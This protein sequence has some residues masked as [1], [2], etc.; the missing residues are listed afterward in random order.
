MLDRWATLP[1]SLAVETRPGLLFHQH[2][3]QLPLLF[4]VLIYS[5]CPTLDAPNLSE[6]SLPPP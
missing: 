3:L 6:D 2:P 5:T 4:S 1:P